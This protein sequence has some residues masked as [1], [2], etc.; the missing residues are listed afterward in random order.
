MQRFAVEMRA[1]VS[2]NTLAGHAAVFGRVAKVPG[3]YEQLDR[4]AFDAALETSD[5]R[6][7]VNHNPDNLLGREGSGTLRLS[8]DSTGLAYELELPDTQLAHDVKVLV[9][10]R[11][12]AGGSF[13]F[14]PGLDKWE[15]ASDGLQLRTHTQ[16]QSLLDAS[17][18]T[19]PAYQGTD[20]ELRAMEITTRPHSG[21]S[22][23]VRAR[24]RLLDRR[25]AR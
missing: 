10:R 4:D 24:A 13:G 6:F 5:A 11:D 15:R 8:T 22:Q 14:I 21:R 2:G 20:V 12:L 16:I 1:E 23:L 19:Y 3:H 7:L 9:Q 25:Y 17:I 18:V